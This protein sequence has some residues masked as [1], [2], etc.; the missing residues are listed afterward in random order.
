MKKIIV[1]ETCHQCPHFG[2]CK[3]WK[4]L[5]PTQRVRLKVGTG[6][7][8]FILKDCP[9]QDIDPFPVISFRELQ[10][11]DIYEP[12]MQKYIREVLTI[13]G[14]EESIKKLDDLDKQMKELEPH[15]FAKWKKL[16]AKYM[17]YLSLF[18]SLKSNDKT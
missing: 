18:F 12:D 13:K 11:T 3:A 6:I 8:K 15:A 17:Q 9:L 5:T 4:K 14:G 16:N 10:N 1:I 2:T 7:G